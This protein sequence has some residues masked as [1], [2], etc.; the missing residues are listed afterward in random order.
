MRDNWR[1]FCDEWKVLGLTKRAAHELAI[2]AL[3][4]TAYAMGAMAMG[5]IPAAAKHSEAAKERA[6]KAIV[7]SP[8]QCP[9]RQ[10]D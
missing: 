5:D 7:L 2:E 1:A 9:H 10:H 3:R 4:E 6:D 8:V